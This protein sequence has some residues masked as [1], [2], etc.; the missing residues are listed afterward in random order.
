MPEMT[1]ADGTEDRPVSNVASVTLDISKD[2]VPFG[3]RH[4]RYRA[5]GS[6]PAAFCQVAPSYLHRGLAAD[7]VGS[8]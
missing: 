2:N 8:W 7:I 1:F 6:G 3:G 4:G 5:G